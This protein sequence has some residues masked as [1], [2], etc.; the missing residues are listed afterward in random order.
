MGRG[1]PDTFQMRWSFFSDAG[2]HGFLSRQRLILD[3]NQRCCSQCG[4]SSNVLDQINP[5]VSLGRLLHLLF[6]PSYCYAM[7]GRDLQP[8]AE[9]T[10]DLACPGAWPECFEGN[11]AYFC[12]EVLFAT[13]RPSVQVLLEGGDGTNL[14]ECVYADL[15][16]IKERMDYIESRFE[17][18]EYLN[19]ETSEIVD[20]HGYQRKLPSLVLFEEAWVC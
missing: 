4:S 11:Y 16:S 2:L 13:E 6:G 19:S 8:A 17:E 12:G 10:F 15:G 7:A 5:G 18:A 1:G 3:G 14:Q 20:L 9:H